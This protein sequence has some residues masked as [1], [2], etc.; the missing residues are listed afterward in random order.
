MSPQKYK[1]VQI[2]LFKMRYNSSLPCFEWL[3]YKKINH[4]LNRIIMAYVAIQK[5]NNN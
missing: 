4:P 2:L 1:Q 3:V 5:I